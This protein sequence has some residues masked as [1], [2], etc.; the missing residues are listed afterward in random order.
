MIKRILSL[1][2]AFVGCIGMVIATAFV[3]LT[4][5][6]EA[7]IFGFDIE[8]D[9]NGNFKMPASVLMAEDIFVFV[10]RLLFMADP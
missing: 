3:V 5:P 8:E 4:L 7:L 2:V 6:L 10:I 9:E 1:I